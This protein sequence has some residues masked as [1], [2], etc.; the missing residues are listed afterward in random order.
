MYANL[1]QC[2]LSPRKI[3]EAL[4]SK[5]TQLAEPLSKQRGLVGVGAA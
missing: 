1:R 2:T 3:A 5:D 4:H